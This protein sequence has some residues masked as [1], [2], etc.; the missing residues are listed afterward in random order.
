MIKS[1]LKKCYKCENINCQCIQCTYYY[2]NNCKVKMHYIP[3]YNNC[4]KLGYNNKNN[5]E[6][7]EELNWS[8]K[9]KYRKISKEIIDI[10]K[11]NMKNYK[12]IYNEQI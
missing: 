9:I 2:N 4:Y 8:D 3:K 1:K 11:C 7:F 6:N 10:K 5:C 12:G